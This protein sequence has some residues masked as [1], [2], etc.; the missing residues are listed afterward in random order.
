MKTQ[1]LKKF[2]ATGITLAGLSFTL[3]SRADVEVLFGG[4]N[5]SQNVLYDRVTN[6]FG[7]GSTLTSVLISPTNSTVRTYKGTI[8]GQSGLGNVTIDFS[9]L[10]AI[11][12]LQDLANQNNETKAYT[13]SLAPTVA[14]SSSSPDAANVSPSSFGT[15][16]TTLATPYAFVKNAAKSPNLA[17]VTNLTQRQANYLEG[18]AGFLPSAFFGGS[19]TN[20]AVYL[21]A[22]N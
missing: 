10:G 6:I 9:L 8:P 15:P 17:G 14:V 19:S 1:T 20:D 2:V 5:A 12:G 11:G 22:R 13:N 16:Y 3:T 7:G 21:V 4:G 18:A